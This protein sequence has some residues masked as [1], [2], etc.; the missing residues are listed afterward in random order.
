[1][2]KCSKCLQ[3]KSA[4]SFAKNKARKSGRHTECKDCQVQYNRIWFMRYH[5][6]LPED[7]ACAYINKIKVEAF[8]EICSEQL[9]LKRNGYAID[10]N[11]NTGKV[12]GLL[13]TSCNQ[14]LGRFKDDLYLLTKAHK[15]LEKYGTV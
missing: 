13:C 6:G 3:L 7:Q 1:M 5:Y 4:H 12:R 8:C 14:G 15:Y 11:H 2:F 10:H 9:Q